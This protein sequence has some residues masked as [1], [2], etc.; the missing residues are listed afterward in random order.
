VD[1]IAAQLGVQGL[2]LR[3]ARETDF[4]SIEDYLD[5]FEEDASVEIDGRPS[6]VGHQELAAAARE[7][8]DAGRVGPDS[9]KYHLVVPGI[10]D[11]DGDRATCESRFL[12]VGQADAGPSVVSVGRYHDRLRRSAGAWKLHTRR[13]EFG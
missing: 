4:G 6:R 1:D 9:K 7:G 12:F 10:V 11:V 5:C 13:I 3:L 8:R 2:L